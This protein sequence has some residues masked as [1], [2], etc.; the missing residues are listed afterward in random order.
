MRLQSQEDEFV[1][2]GLGRF[3]TAVATTLAKYEHNILAI[4]DD[5]ER[6]QALS[7]ELP[8]VMQLDATNIDALRQAGVDNFDTAIVCI[9]SDFESNVLATVLLNRLGLK[10]V[11]TKARTQMQ[12]EIL[13]Q[14]GADEVILPELEAGVRLARRMAADHFVDY[15][16]MSND[17]G[18]VELVSP[19]SMWGRTLAETNLRQR[20]QLTAIA[21]RRGEELIV[22]PS[23]AF[24]LEPNDFLVVL[25]RLAD[26]E[27]LTQ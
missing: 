1:V 14:I 24:R 5:M 25:G 19:S 15:L 12:K 16:E 4:D 10:R 21:V 3:G 8:H 22:S 9:G 20:Y 2:I 7:T 11:I 6:V 26:A 13:L 27:R 23:A 18:I 17:V